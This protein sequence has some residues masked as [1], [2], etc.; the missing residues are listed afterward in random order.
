MRLTTRAVPPGEGPPHAPGSYDGYM[1]PESY[2]V[3]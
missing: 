1:Y 2:Y 3:V